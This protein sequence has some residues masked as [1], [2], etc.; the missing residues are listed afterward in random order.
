MELIEGLYLVTTTVLAGASVTLLAF[1]VSA[2]RSSGRTAMAYLAVGFGLV[3][4]AAVATPVA[5][6]R[7]SFANPQALLLVNTGLLAASMALV[8]GS[9]AVY[10]P[11]TREFVIPDS[12]L[13]QIQDR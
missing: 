8:A 1:A 4:L 11:G 6:F 5:A 10:E 13:A 7:T 3:V 9:L 12:E 2:Y